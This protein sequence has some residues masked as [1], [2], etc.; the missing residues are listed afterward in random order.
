MFCAV[1]FT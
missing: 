1:G